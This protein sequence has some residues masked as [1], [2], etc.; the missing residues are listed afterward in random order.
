M[1]ILFVACLPKVPSFS[2]TLAQR[3][4]EALIGAGHEVEWHELYAEGFDPLLDPSELARATSFD[5]LVLAHGRALVEAE[6]LA[7]V[8]PDWWGQSPAIL[9]GW[10]DRVFR[11]GVA[12]ELSGEDGFE[13]EWR[14]LLG[15]KKAFVLV[16]SDT[17]DP[18][19]SELF[20]SIWV[21]ATLGACGMEAECLLIDR[22]RERSPE[23]RDKA[24]RDALAAAL[25]RFGSRR[26]D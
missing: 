22:L 21:G 18:S 1:K 6:G 9:K 8:H 25:L 2:E 7:I 17:R 24:L 19:R 11:E 15:G 10:V 20:R 4:R 14:P 5:T 16:T 26:E 13:K 3:L 12:Y 23:E